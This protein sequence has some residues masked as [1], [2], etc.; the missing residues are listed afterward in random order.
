MQVSAT[1]GSGNSDGGDLTHTSRHISA[2]NT[3]LLISGNDTNIIGGQVS[4]HAVMADI[5]HN[6][7]ISSPQDS[8]T[9]SSHDKQVG[10]SATTGPA[11]AL[12]GSYSANRVTGDYA[13]VREQS[14]LLAGDGGFDVSVKGNTDL[15]GA[16]I[17]STQGAENAGVNH[18][19]TGTLTQ[20]RHRQPRPLQLHWYQFIRW[21]RPER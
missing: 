15:K 14:G 5:G 9:Y 1:V 3:A 8:S 11:G 21:N 2:G 19:E 20:R 18:L 4:G 10:V 13:S 17:A 7:T 6:L 12:N 16:V